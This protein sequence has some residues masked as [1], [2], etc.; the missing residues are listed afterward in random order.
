MMAERPF[1]LLH[2]AALLATWFGAGLLPWA[3]GTWGSL[4]A[5][6]F[7]WAIATLFGQPALLIAAAIVFCVGWWAAEQVGRASGVADQGSIVID[8]VVGQW[9]TLTVVPPSAAA[10]VLGFLLFRLF[11]I[12]KPW[13]ASAAERTIS[14]GLGVMADD[15][16]AGIYAALLL[17]AVHAIGRALF[18]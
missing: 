10:Y 6:P 2:P 8:E 12:T 16:V 18:G 11:D 9:L 3:P 17:Y 7:A 5:L 4:A 15:I 13:P 14:G 1:P